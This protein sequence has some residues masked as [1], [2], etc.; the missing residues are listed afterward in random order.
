MDIKAALSLG[1][2]VLAAICTT[3]LIGMPA[4]APAAEPVASLE[5]IR[6][7]DGDSGEDAAKATVVDPLGNLIVTGYS[8]RAPGGIDYFT[9]KYDTRGKVLWTRRY[10][11]IG[12]GRDEAVDVA[13]DVDGNVVV[14]GSSFT[15][16]ANG[17]DIVTLKY[18]PNGNLLWEARHSG[19]GG[20]D[21]TPGAVAV[22]PFGNV[23]VTGQDV[24][25]DTALDFT[26]IKYDPGGGNL[27]TV[28]YNG[29]TDHDDAGRAIAID[30]D[31]NIYVTG[32][33]FG[34]AANGID[35][36]TF[37]YDPAGTRLWRSRYNNSYGRYDAAHAIDIDASGNV[38]VTGESMDWLGSINYITL[39]YNSAGRERWGKRY[40]GPFY[41]TDAALSV[42]VDPSGNVV[43]TGIS[44]GGKVT[45]DDIATAKY[46][47]DGNVLWERRFDG[48]GS[49]QDGGNALAI[50]AEGNI[51]VAGYSQG[52]NNG[53][54]YALLRY[55]P[56]GNLRWAWRY[57]GPASGDDQAAELAVDALGGIFVTG[58]S[59]GIGTGSDFATMKV[60]ENLLPT[61]LVLRPSECF[62]GMKAVFIATLGERETFKPL[63]GK[64]IRFFL[65]DQLLA[66]AVLTN[67]NGIARLAYTMPEGT[68]VGTHRLKAR[69][70]GDETYAV[71]YRT[72]PVE[73]MK[74]PSFLRV[75]P[76][77]TS[78]G[79]TLNLGARLTNGSGIPLVGR[80]L[81]VFLAGEPLGTCA[82]NALGVGG[83]KYTV[84][85]GTP[86]GTYELRVEF[87]GDETH[88]PVQG[89]G[90]L[91]VG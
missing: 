3:G 7:Y 45:N 61:E 21:D 15:D 19:P 22:D 76:K 49:G 17:M 48:P 39:K 59:L 89:T 81:K 63:A 72:A 79:Q 75:Y 38:F 77:S 40:T 14:T 5:W 91:T 44:N 87:E 31:G 8:Y 58:S 10:D 73:A 13:V 50:D 60:T 66:D 53:L 90:T 74:G 54:N 65:D 78:A 84:P 46:D 86:G 28:R 85:A 30:A 12:H 47:T 32:Y 29:L 80:T 2:W 18:D 4:Q 1:R 25:I 36:C 35:Y 83:I 6:R 70:G 43:V 16:E 9:I 37:K 57:N 67:S 82:T 62:V 20:G 33:S 27:W 52:W 55:D 41:G 88:E 68:T 26:T 42:K 56:L 11:G 51:T 24:G 23:V 69:F 71:S 34:G 64:P